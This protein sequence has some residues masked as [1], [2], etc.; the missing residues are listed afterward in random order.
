MDLEE[1]LKL[2]FLLLITRM[3]F[4][5]LISSVYTLFIFYI[6]LVVPLSLYVTPS[7]LNNYPNKWKLGSKIVD[8]LIYICGIK[9]QFEG[10][11][12]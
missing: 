12:I 1:C 7:K 4:E 9:I 10:Q 8:Q 11:I 5:L 6:L 2:L 3:E